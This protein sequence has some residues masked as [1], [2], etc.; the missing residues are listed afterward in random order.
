MNNKEQ[1]N[2]LDIIKEIDHLEF[3][4]ALEID[5]IQRM[6]SFEKKLAI[7]DELKLHL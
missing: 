6:D 5:Y 4:P 7:F 3:N 1:A 2:H